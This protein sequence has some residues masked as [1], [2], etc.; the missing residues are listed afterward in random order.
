M[1]ELHT[2][3]SDFHVVEAC[4]HREACMRALW[5]AYKFA[6][7]TKLDRWQFA[8][9]LSAMIRLGVEVTDIRWMVCSELIEHR[10][11]TTHPGQPARSFADDAGLTFNDRSSF[12]LTDRGIRMTEVYLPEH[13]PGVELCQT[14]APN[15][16]HVRRELWHD[17][18]LVKRFSKPAK[19]QELVLTA[20][21]EENWPIEG[22]FDPLPGTAQCD[23]RSR[24]RDTVKS[25]NRN[26]VGERLIHFSS[27][28]HGELVYWRVEV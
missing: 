17:D 18:L 26:Q 11:E 6:N 28:S 27:D 7:R 13:Q 21:Q 2:E 25:L 20:M 1:P 23:R 5:K 4:D 16:N 24:L 12:V 9:E 10:R 3:S 22:V 14:R 15:W 19:N 8:I